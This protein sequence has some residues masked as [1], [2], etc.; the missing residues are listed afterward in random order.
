MVAFKEKHGNFLGAGAKISDPPFLH[1]L[2]PQEKHL[3]IIRDFLYEGDWNEVIEDLKARKS[4]Q[5][6]IFRWES[7]IQKDLQ[8]IQK[9]REYEQNC[10]S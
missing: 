7:P 10:R 5:P 4:G 8:S 6:G 3:L 1:W 2:T 9:M